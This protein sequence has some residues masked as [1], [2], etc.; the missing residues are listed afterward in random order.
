MKCIEFLVIPDSRSHTLTTVDDYEDIF[1][2]D[3]VE[4]FKKAANI[5]IKITEI[6]EGRQQ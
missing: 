1:K 2:E 6:M 5:I 4:N 3:D